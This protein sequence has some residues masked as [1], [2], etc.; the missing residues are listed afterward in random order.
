MKEYIDKCEG[1]MMKELLASPKNQSGNQWKSQQPLQDG[2]N[3]ILVSL[4]TTLYSIKKIDLATDK[5]RKR[6]LEE[7]DIEGD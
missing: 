3:A 5:M 2:S 1:K 4:M 7:P 6:K